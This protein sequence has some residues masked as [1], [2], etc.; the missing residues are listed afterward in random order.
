MHTETRIIERL[1]KLLHARK[2]MLLD[3]YIQLTNWSY[4]ALNCP[5][6]KKTSTRQS[7]AQLLVALQILF[8]VRLLHLSL[9]AKDRPWSWET[10]GEVAGKRGLDFGDG[11]CC[12]HGIRQ[13]GF[14]YAWDSG[15]AARISRLRMKAVTRDTL[16]GHL[17]DET[18]AVSRL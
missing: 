10:A 2:R 6:I 4:R 14:E 17:D 3:D 11:R 12:T 15:H 13:F 16:P 9:N 8:I 5:I 1:S 7:H 18:S